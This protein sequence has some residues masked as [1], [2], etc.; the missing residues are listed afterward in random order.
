VDAK[1]PLMRY[2]K[3]RSSSTITFMKKTCNCGLHEGHSGFCR[4]DYPP[5]PFRKAFLITQ[6]STWIKEPFMSAITVNDGATSYQGPEN[7]AVAVN[8]YFPDFIQN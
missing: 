1:A 8:K 4:A 3:F 2:T 6:L 7:R 5:A